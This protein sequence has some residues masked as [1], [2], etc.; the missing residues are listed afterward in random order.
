MTDKLLNYN[1]ILG[2]DILHEVEIIFIFE[3][4]TI[5]C[6]KV[7]FSTKPPNCMAKEYFVIKESLSVQNRTKRKQQILDAEYKKINFKTIFMN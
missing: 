3:N 2:R 7:S 4:K 6:Q 5:T 1:L